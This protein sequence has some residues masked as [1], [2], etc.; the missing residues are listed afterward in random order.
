LR[1][2]KVFSEQELIGVTDK[3]LERFSHGNAK[4]D[5][6]TLDYCLWKAKQFLFSKGYLKATFGEPKKQETQDG[7]R[8]IVPINEGAL[9]RLGEVKIE[10]S[11]L[12]SPAQILEMLTLKTGDIVDADSLSVWFFERVAKAYGNFGYIQY[13]AEPELKFHLKEGGREGVVDLTVTIDEGHVFTIRSIKFEGNGS[14]PEHTLFREM[15]VRNG[16][17]FNKELF[18]ESLK[19][20]SQSGQFEPIDAEKDVDYKWDQKSPRLDLTIHLKKKAAESEETRN[21]ARL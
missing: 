16:E 15:L 7:L 4:D 6:V 5:Y 8:V 1:V 13:T 3:C 12:F 9:F 10:G 20:I 17:V 21:C 14:V 2:N 11:T 18:V 19:R